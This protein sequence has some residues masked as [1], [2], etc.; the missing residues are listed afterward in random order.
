MRVGR[1]VDA[2]LVDWKVERYRKVIEFLNSEIGDLPGTS[3]II[4][5]PAER[6][7]EYCWLQKEEFLPWFRFLAFVIG[8]VLVLY[9]C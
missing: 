4:M 2:K 9:C 7:K 5:F 8:H 1:R 3:V 6:T